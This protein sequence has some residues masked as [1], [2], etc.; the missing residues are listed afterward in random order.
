[1]AF[2]G[3]H[4]NKNL[5]G[6]FGRSRVHALDDF[7]QVH[8]LCAFFGAAELAVKVPEVHTGRQGHAALAFDVLAHLVFDGV[9][10]AVRV[11]AFN[12]KFERFSH[13]RP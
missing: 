12:L 3:H 13:G 1:M 5:H 7:G 4:F 8:R 6:A 10:H 2:L 11:F 9:Q